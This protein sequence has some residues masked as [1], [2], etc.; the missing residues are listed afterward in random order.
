ML[1]LIKSLVLIYAVLSPYYIFQSGGLQPSSIFMIAAFSLFL[2]LSLSSKEDKIRTN[3]SGILH[4]HKHLVYFVILATGINV[5]WYIASPD[6]ELMLSS[7]YLVFNVLVVLMFSGI[8]KD[9]RFLS[10]LSG[11]LQFNIIAQL[12][13]YLFNLGR[14]YSPDRYMGTFNDP[15]QLAFYIFISLIVTFIIRNLTSKSTTNKLNIATWLAGL[16][17]IYSSGSTGVLLGIMVFILLGTL[18]YVYSNTLKMKNRMRADVVRLLAT[19]LFIATLL[20]AAWTYSQSSESAWVRSNNTSSETLLTDR[21]EEKINKAS[22]DA[23]I[24]LAEDRGLDIIYKY[25]HYIFFGA[26]AGNYNRYTEAAQNTGLEIHSTL[27]LIFYY[28]LIPSIILCMWFVSQ[29]RKASSWLL[30]SAAAILI[31]SLFLINY[32]QPLFWIAFTLIGLHPTARQA[33]PDSTPDQRRRKP[34]TTGLTKKTRSF[35]INKTK[36]A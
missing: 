18:H 17:L 32:R 1:S 8:S 19:L 3:I 15:N 5:L 13:I 24:T 7:F 22:G 31:E 28:G 20:I 16:F 25:H 2:Y 23:D 30:I 12:F 34:T 35:F 9:D 11:L 10:K 33:M 21:L 4:T 29:L 26:G 6:K 14:H 36:E 27:S